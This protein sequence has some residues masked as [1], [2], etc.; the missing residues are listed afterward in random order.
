MTLINQY[1]FPYAAHNVGN[2]H[3][4]AMKNEGAASSTAGTN[5]YV[6]LHNYTMLCNAYSL[7]VCAM[8]A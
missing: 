3:S 8:Y 1:I 6:H 5:T 2:Y 7:C 4:Q